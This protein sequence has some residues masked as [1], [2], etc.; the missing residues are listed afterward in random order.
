M[1]LDEWR[2]N[3][4]NSSCRGDGRRFRPRTQRPARRG[5]R[6]RTTWQREHHADNRRSHLRLRLGNT[7]SMPNG[8]TSAASMISDAVA[9]SVYD[10][11]VYIPVRR[12]YDSSREQ[13]CLTNVE[14][15]KAGAQSLVMDQSMQRAA[16]RRAAE[17][18]LYFSHT[19]PNGT[20]CWT[21][22]PSDNTTYGENIAAGYSTTDG[23]PEPYGAAPSPTWRRGP[24]TRAR[25][26]SCAS[27]T[28][29]P[30]R[31]GR[32]RA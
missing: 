17:T 6:R 11:G 18:A 14:R 1:F 10:N 29:A 23:T 30:C 26:A 19:R 22:F 4:K 7:S 12:D 27:T 31:P 24:S 15:S 8:Y 20:S 3:T 2:S 9:G 28:G 32:S 5:R 25:W 13:L 16:M 21:A